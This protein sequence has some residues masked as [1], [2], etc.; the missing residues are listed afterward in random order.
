MKHNDTLGSLGSLVLLV[1]CIIGLMACPL[2][3]QSIDKWSVRIYNVGAVA[4]LFGPLDLLATNVQCNQVAPPATASTINPTRIVFDDAVNVGKVC[5]WTDPGTGV[6]TA[7]PFGA[8][9]YE[10]T[11]TAT[12]VAGTTGESNRAPFTRPGALPGVPSGLRLV[13]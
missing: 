4:P 6:L 9:A 11:V 13:R 12:N 2:H 1:A 5:I 10:G 3:A 7:V 8:A